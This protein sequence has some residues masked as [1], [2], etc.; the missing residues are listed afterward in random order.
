M[1]NAG[2]LPSDCPTRSSIYARGLRETVRSGTRYRALLPM[3]ARH[4][5]Y[6]FWPT[7]ECVNVEKDR[8]LTSTLTSA[9]K[10][11]T[12]LAAFNISVLSLGR[13]MVAQFL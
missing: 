8:K 7:G 1:D 9:S 12:T 4:A 6:S 13:P 10:A 11:T 2:D 5:C 3:G